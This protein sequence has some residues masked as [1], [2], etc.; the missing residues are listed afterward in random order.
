MKPRPGSARAVGVL[1]ALCL[2]LPVLGKP[3][4]GGGARK[5]EPTIA[6]LMM[7]RDE[8]V[9]VSWVGV[10]LER[11]V[12]KD[13]GDLLGRG[14]TGEPPAQPAFMGGCLRLLRGGHRQ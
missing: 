10:A 13:D 2:G 1:L 14:L 11:E 4:S 8:E 3:G 6:M 12:P 9:S 7:V 5:P